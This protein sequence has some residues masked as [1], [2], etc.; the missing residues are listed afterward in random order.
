MCTVLYCTTATG[1]LPDCSQQ[2]YLCH[3][4][5][6]V[7]SRFGSTGIF[8]VRYCKGQHTKQTHRHLKKFLHHLNK[9]KFLQLKNSKLQSSHYTNVPSDLLRTVRGS[10]GIREAQLG[11]HWQCPLPMYLKECT[12]YVYLKE[13]T[14]SVYLKECTLS[15]YLK[16]CT[17]IMYLKECTLSMYLKECTLSMYLNAVLLWPDDGCLQPKYVALKFY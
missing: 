15:M 6:K 5:R 14:H 17:L 12:I 8:L 13:F 2:I 4:I 7:V 16:E 11:N 9:T 1:W 10:L 3:I